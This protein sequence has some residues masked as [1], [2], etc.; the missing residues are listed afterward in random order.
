MPSAMATLRGDTK[1]LR[2]VSSCRLIS[3]NSEKAN[4]L[5]AWISC[6]SARLSSRGSA[7]S[8]PCGSPPQAASTPLREQSIE[9]NVRRMLILRWTD[10]SL[11]A[12]TWIVY[13]TG[14]AGELVERAVR[15]QG[16]HADT[17]LY[18]EA[19]PRQSWRGR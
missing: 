18:G 7:V 17:H 13:S 2:P 1:T 12:A 8:G 10:Q 4:A 9:T 14:G 5:S 6:C 15:A 19:E 16:S 11:K 3:R